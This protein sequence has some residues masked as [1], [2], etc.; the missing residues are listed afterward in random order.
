VLAGIA[1]TACRA[2]A[3]KFADLAVAGIDRAIDW[4]VA[5]R[6]DYRSLSAEFDRHRRE[7]GR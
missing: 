1:R 4:C 7:Q 2:A 6:E 5:A 3:L